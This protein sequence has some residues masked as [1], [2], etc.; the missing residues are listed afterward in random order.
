MS[1]TGM[2]HCLDSL[3]GSPLPVIVSG[4]DPLFE[5]IDIDLLTLQPGLWTFGIF[6][7]LLLPCAFACHFGRE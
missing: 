6:F 1:F 4:E 2:P 3:F 7:L 5:L